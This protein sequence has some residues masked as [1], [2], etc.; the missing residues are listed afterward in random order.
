MKTIYLIKFTLCLIG[1]W[2][3]CH[4]GSKYVL[5]WVMV[6]MLMLAFF[7]EETITDNKN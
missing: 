5:L 3:D 2:Y 1:A 4:T 6:G 7:L